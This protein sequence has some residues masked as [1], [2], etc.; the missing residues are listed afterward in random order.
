MQDM[1]LQRTVFSS[2][3]QDSIYI[4]GE[5]LGR[6]LR[7]TPVKRIFQQQRVLMS[8]HL[9]PY[10]TQGSLKKPQAASTSKKRKANGKAVTVVN[11]PVGTRTEHF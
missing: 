7:E 9:V 5:I 4:P 8:I 2:V 6:S 11:G 3:R 10:L 1:D